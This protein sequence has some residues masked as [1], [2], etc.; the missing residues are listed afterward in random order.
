MDTL[1]Y[2]QNLLG[3]KYGKVISVCKGGS[4]LYT[5]EGKSKICVPL[6]EPL[7]EGQ[8]IGRELSYDL[9]DEEVLFVE[10]DKGL[11]VK[12]GTIYRFYPKGSY[13]LKWRG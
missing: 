3:E 8:T 7:N 10:T 4:W 2:I 13:Q 11:I 5:K 9:L 6:F 12:D 1:E